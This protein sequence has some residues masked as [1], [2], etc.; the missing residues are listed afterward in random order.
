MTEYMFTF[1]LYFEAI[2]ILTSCK[3][4]LDRKYEAEKVCHHI[5]PHGEFYENVNYS[6]TKNIHQRIYGLGR[7]SCNDV[8]HLIKKE[9]KEGKLT[10]ITGYKKNGN[11]WYIVPFKNEIENGWCKTYYKDGS[12]YKYFRYKNGLRD[13]LYMKRFPNGEIKDKRHY[14]NGEQRGNSHKKE[15][16]NK[17]ITNIVNM[18][19]ITEIT[20]Y[21]LPLTH[22]D[23]QDIDFEEKYYFCGVLQRKTITYYDKSVT[24]IEYYNS[25]SK[26]SMKSVD[27]YY[28]SVGWEMKWSNDGKIRKCIFHGD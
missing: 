12:M 11:I 16:K 14:I 5:Q 6:R 15:L 17:T 9:Y 28:S 2:Q 3:T 22:H 24:T 8:D 4:L 10:S 23:I 21:K 13:G 19:T 20:K 27:D 18:D 7:K 25:G 1:L 26:K